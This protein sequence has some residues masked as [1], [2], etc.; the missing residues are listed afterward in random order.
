MAEAIEDARQMLRRDIGLGV[1]QLSR[2]TRPLVANN[3]LH[4]V[5]GRGVLGGIVTQNAQNLLDP[6]CRAT[7][8][9]ASSSSL[10]QLEL[11]TALPGH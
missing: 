10:R 4:T 8:T 5:A 7:S 11:D 2:D 3:Q 9:G 6:V 1:G